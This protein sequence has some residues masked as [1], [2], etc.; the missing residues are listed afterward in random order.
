MPVPNKVKYQKTLEKLSTKTFISKSKM[1]L[2]M[3]EE[4]SFLFRWSENISK[5]QLISERNFDVFKSPK[6][7]NQIFEGFLP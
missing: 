1:N 7:T 2:A 3:H 5:G 6:K 4:R